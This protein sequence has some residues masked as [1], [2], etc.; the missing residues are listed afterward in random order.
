MGYA[1]IGYASGSH[2]ML[3]HQQ[4]VS[5]EIIALMMGHHESPSGKYAA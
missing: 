5:S 2:L 4:E 1:S 3:G